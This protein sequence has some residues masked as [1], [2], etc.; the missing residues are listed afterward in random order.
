MAE[1]SKGAVVV[2]KRARRAETSIRT[3]MFD[4]VEGQRIRFAC[5]AD[6]LVFIDSHDPGMFAL[7]ED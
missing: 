7:S 5:E 1:K 6:A 2:C 4:Y 3:T